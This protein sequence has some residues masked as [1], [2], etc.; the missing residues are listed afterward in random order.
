MS[1][2]ISKGLSCIILS[3]LKSRAH[4][5]DRAINYTGIIISAAAVLAIDFSEMA[6]LV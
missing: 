2:V 6:S 3:L 5:D 1:K 4:R